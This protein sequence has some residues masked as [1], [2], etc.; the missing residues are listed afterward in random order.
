MNSINSNLPI[1]SRNFIHTK[2]V[3]IN[4]FM[5]VFSGITDNTVEGECDKTTAMSG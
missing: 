2:Y 3:S 4:P 1:F 5:L